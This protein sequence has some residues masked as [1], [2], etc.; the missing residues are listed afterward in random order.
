MATREVFSL[1]DGKLRMIATQNSVTRSSGTR[2]RY[3]I[4]LAPDKFASAWLHDLT[5][6][7]LVALHYALV[8]ELARTAITQQSRF[9]R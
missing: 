1:M 6:H 3:A 5:R 7:H 9:G 8:Q 2:T 4:E